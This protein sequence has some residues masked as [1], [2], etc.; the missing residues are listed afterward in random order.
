MTF[1]FMSELRQGWLLSAW[2]FKAVLDG[3]ANATRQEKR[4]NSINAGKKDKRCYEDAMMTYPKN[5]GRETLSSANRPT[6]TYKCENSFPWYIPSANNQKTTGRDAIYLS[7]K[8]FKIPKTKLKKW[9]GT[10]RREPYEQLIEQTEV[11]DE[12]SLSDKDSNALR[13]H[14]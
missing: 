1:P 7:C 4:T 13:I 5:P 3:A 11:S 6:V 2:L 14:L 10:Y 12:K 9:A 8:Q